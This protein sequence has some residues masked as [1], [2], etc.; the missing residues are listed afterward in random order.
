M[1]RP[2]SLP[3]LAKCPC[4]ESDQST[5]REDKSAGQERHRYLSA[6]IKTVLGGNDGGDIAE[7]ESVELEDSDKEAVSWAADYILV[8]APTSE[9]P[10]RLEHHVNPR[11]TE[12][13]P[14]F[15]N[16]GTLDAACGNH[17]FDFKWRRRDYGAQMAA[18]ALDIFQELGCAEVKVHLLFGESKQAEVYTLTEAGCVDLVFGIIARVLDPS[19]KPAIND[20]CG[21]CARRLTCP[22][23]LSVVEKVS[24]GYAEDEKVKS[25]HPSKMETGEEIGAA[26]SVWRTVLKKFG[27]SIEFHALEANQKRG[28]TIAGFEAKSKAGKAYVPDVPAAFALTGL[29]QAEFLAGCQVRMN[30]S[31]KYPDQVGLVDVFAKFNGLKKAAAKRDLLKKLEPVVKQTRPSTYLKA[32]GVEEEESE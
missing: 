8:H 22:A 9:Y 24:H 7:A 27:E 10:L 16:G 12:F 31:K 25:W 30:T 11:D 17:L 23:I 21:W 20:Y 29:P 18:Y 26:L 32:V 28:L 2:S 1:I 14:I 6:L 13:Q 15:T 5:G 19:R 3:F 4:W